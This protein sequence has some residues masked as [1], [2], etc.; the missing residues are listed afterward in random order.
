MAKQKTK[1]ITCKKR[2]VSQDDWKN[3]EERQN[4]LTCLVL[5]KTI[6][7]FLEALKNSSRDKGLYLTYSFMLTPLAKEK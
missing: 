3:E 6:K 4:C 5:K 1:C 2:Y 7:G